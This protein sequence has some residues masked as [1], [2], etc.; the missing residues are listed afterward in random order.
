MNTAENMS[1]QE[2]SKEE[3]GE[4]SPTI[5]SILGGRADI[6]VLSESRRSKWVED[7][8]YMGR[9]CSYEIS[10][11]DLTR[12]G[13]ML[14]TELSVWFPDDGYPAFSLSGKKKTG[15]AN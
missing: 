10:V 1:G 6:N 2:P 8:H 5:E 12:P 11:P 15:N 9:V 4:T 3:R 13:E 14:T 7:V